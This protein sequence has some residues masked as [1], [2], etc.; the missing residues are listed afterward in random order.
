MIKMQSLRQA[1]RLAWAGAALLGIGIL[2]L[3]GS[4]LAVAQS[5]AMSPYQDEKDGVP[6]GGKWMEFHSEDKMTGAKKV[7]F[8]LVA[9]NFFKEDPD[10]KPRVELYCQ[11]GKLKLADF[12]PGVRLPP[13]NRPGFWGQPQLEVLVRIDDTHSY[14]GWNWVRG[15]FLSMDKGTT[16]GMIGAQIFKVELPTASGRQIAEF[17]P[18]G[19]EVDRVRQACDITPKKPSKD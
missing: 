6:A 5:G 7:R 13:P 2:I 18:G 11:D 8:E 16:R 12:N 3:C 9:D 15:H 19:L 4:R 1:S 17:S 14:H 10:Y